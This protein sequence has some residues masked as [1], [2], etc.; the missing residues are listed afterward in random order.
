MANTSKPLLA[1][2]HLFFVYLA[3]ILLLALTSLAAQLPATVWS[4]PIA[5]TIAFAKVALIFYF[6][7]HLRLHGGLVRV[8]ALAASSRCSPRMPRLISRRY[9]L[10]R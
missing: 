3:L 8:F 10:S 6:F 1:T 4:L 9:R 5:M 2:K 7:M